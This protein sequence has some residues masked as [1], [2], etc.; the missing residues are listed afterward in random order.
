MSGGKCGTKTILVT[1]KNYAAKVKLDQFGFVG[2]SNVLNQLIYLRVIS[3]HKQADLTIL[4]L[5]VSNQFEDKCYQMKPFRL[6]SAAPI[7]RNAFSILKIAKEKQLKLYI[8]T[9]LHLIGCSLRRTKRFLCKKPDWIPIR[10]FVQQIS[11]PPPGGL[12]INYYSSGCNNRIT[13]HLP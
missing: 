2:K 1:L 12:M 6:F 7:N 13:P 3:F 8:R 11:L 10:L 5:L 9:H 4:R